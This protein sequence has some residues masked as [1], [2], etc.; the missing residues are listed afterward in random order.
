MHFIYNI[1]S[2]LKYAAQNTFQLLWGVLL[3][4]KVGFPPWQHYVFMMA[5]VFAGCCIC[6]GICISAS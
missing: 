6:S 2:R 3:S 1:V 5:S 4:I